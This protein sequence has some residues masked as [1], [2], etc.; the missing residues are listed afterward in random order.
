MHNFQ[1]DDVKS[2]ILLKLKFK[3]IRKIKVYDDS[4]I[5][6][7]L[8]LIVF[9]NKL[10]RLNKKYEYKKIVGSLVFSLSLVIFSGCGG[11]MPSSQFPLLDSAENFSE[12]GFADS[13]NF[14]TKQ[15]SEEMISF[16]RVEL[17][18]QEIVE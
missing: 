18:S 11:G 6:F 16:Y 7:L 14:Q 3:I 10:I 9:Y 15:S 2:A 8:L 12:L 1:Q 17:T 13:I 4:Q 5:D